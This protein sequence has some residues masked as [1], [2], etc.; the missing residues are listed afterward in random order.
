MLPLGSF[1]TKLS[2]ILSKLELKFRLGKKLCTKLLVCCL[3]FY[4]QLGNSL[5]FL[6]KAIF[7]ISDNYLVDKSTRFG[8]AF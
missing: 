6:N 7:E 4:K 3:D 8:A 1:D 2:S 5:E